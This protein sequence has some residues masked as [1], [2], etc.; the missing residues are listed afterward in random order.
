MPRYSVPPGSQFQSVLVPT[1]DT[2]RN[3]WLIDQLIL[4]TKHVLCVGDTGTGKSVSLLNKLQKELNKDTYVPILLSFSA[5]T[6]ANQTQEIIDGR[7]TRLR[8]VRRSCRVWCASVCLNVSRVRTASAGCVCV[9]VC[10]VVCIRWLVP[11]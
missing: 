5:Q 6:S 4:N 9:C 1:V 8:K 10:L 11:V 7:L 3:S 2:V